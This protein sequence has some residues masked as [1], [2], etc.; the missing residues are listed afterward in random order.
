MDYPNRTKIRIER[1]EEGSID[2][3]DI[4]ME[5]FYSV[6]YVSNDS[7]TIVFDIPSST[8]KS[9]RKMSEEHK[10]V[11]SKVIVIEHYKRHEVAI[12]KGDYR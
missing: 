1:T 11:I 10:E 7:N 9:V 5:Q 3:I 12:M 8:V 2:D 6:E 4:L